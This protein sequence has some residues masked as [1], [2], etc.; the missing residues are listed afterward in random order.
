[1]QRKIN[2]DDFENFLQQSADQVRMHPSSAVWKSISK[3]LKKKRRRW[4]AIVASILIIVS[5]GGYL[6]SDNINFSSPE[7]TDLA[8]PSGST[9]SPAVQN[10]I[11]NEIKSVEP[12]TQ[13]NTNTIHIES[14]E[15][16]R[17]SATIPLL[18][19]QPRFSERALWIPENLAPD[20]LA[21]ISE[22]ETPLQKRYQGAFNESLTLQRQNKLSSSFYMNKPAIHVDSI[23]VPENAGSINEEK[24]EEVAVNLNTKKERKLSWQLFFSPNIS[25]RKLS[26]NKSFVRPV[27][28]T[29]GSVFNYL[30]FYDVNNAVTHKPDIGFEFGITSRYSVSRNAKLRAGFQF[31]INR[32]NI[33]AFSYIPEVATIALNNGYRVDIV[34]TISNYRNFNGGKTNW[35]KNFYFQASVP[36]GAEVKVTG[37]NKMNVSIASSL[38]P[39]YIIGDRAYMITNDYKNYAELPW[40]IRRWNVNTHL[41]T[42]VSYTTGKTKW[43]VGPQV[44]YQ[45]LSSFVSK[46]PVKENLFD[47]GLKVGVTLNQR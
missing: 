18:S 47:F 25:Y 33:K 10:S 21:Y 17:T 46:Y 23:E 12:A 11:Q 42:F 19:V 2:H 7:T 43:Q 38:Q 24:A 8:K 37:N 9:G 30:S 31:N 22:E 29:P 27:S 3:D 34:N 40:L 44:R 28:T 13:Q 5:T 41:E 35:L 6:F 1:M 16:N 4:F 15:P 39:T 14:S 32:Y 45:L 26:E 36:I 20:K